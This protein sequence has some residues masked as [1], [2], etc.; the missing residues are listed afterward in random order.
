[1]ESKEFLVNAQEAEARL[2]IFLIGRIEGSRSFIQN[3]IKA[4][5]V[6][7]N[8]TVRKPNYRLT[9]GDVVAV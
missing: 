8:Q 5:H 2:D 6:S 9:E 1:M 4:D 3:L 7:V